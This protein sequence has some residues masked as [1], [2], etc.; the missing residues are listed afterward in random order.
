MRTTDRLLFM[1]W[2]PSGILCGYKSPHSSIIIRKISDL[3]QSNG[4]IQLSCNWTIQSRFQLR[5][6]CCRWAKI[7]SKLSIL[8]RQRRLNN[9]TS[10]KLSRIYCSPVTVGWE[11][12]RKLVQQQFLHCC[13]ELQ[14]V[15]YLVGSLQRL[16]L[17]ETIKAVGG[18]VGWIS[19][20]C[21]LRKQVRSLIN[22]IVTHIHIF[23]NDA[24]WSTLKNKFQPTN[25]ILKQFTKT[26]NS[27]ILTNK[28][29]RRAKNSL[30]KH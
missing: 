29:S 18:T 27:A 15:T 4:K 2:R 8:M 25:V 21:D 17:W 3:S 14:E 24:L 1:R 5:L 7:K 20:L 28:I 23:L 22:A 9:A 13:E 30:A 16:L 11:T 19:W 26:P 10:K 6:K 12:I